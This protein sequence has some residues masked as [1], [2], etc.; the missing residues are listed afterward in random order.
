MGQ[1]TPHRKKIILLLNVSKRLR[2]GLILWHELSNGSR[3]SNLVLCRLG[4]S[5]GKFQSSQ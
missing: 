2:L 1:T 4:V 5:A 3:T